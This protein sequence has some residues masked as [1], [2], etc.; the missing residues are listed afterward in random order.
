MPTQQGITGAQGGAQPI[1]VCVVR[2][3][4]VLA[5]EV[6]TSGSHPP[7]RGR[8]E[9]ERWLPVRAVAKREVATLV[10]TESLAT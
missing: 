6:R 9:P 1:R 7:T 10:A 8:R 2:T 4:K 5:S 3:G